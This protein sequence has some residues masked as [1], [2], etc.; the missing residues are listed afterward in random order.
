M[1]P[2][3][4]PGDRVIVDVWSYRQR[5]P[6]NG[7]IVLFSG[8]LPHSAP[9]IKRC[10][11]APPAGRERPDPSRWSGVTNIGAEGCW[12]LGEN[13]GKSWDSRAF[14]SVPRERIVGRVTWCYWPPSRMGRVR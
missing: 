1:A 2:T 14:G 12:L 13:P 10:A 8:P 4:R 3:L 11:P 7:E 9:L 5:A 6:R